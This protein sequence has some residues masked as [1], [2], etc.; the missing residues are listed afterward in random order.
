MRAT[1]LES[2]AA[3]DKITAASTTGG[4][5]GPTLSLK[6]EQPKAEGNP[7]GE[8]MYFVPLISPDLVEVNQNPG[9]LQRVRILSTTR[10]FKAGSFEV[11]GQFEIRGDG[12]QKNTF[13][14]T[15]S[16]R[17]EDKRL[18][19]G[20]VL[21]RQLDT[22][23]VSGACNGR[24]EVEGVISNQA[25]VVTMVRLRFNDGRQSPVSI[26]L[27]DISFADGAFH[28]DN[29]VVARVNALTFRRAPGRPKMEV[30]VGS[31]KDADAGNGF[32]QKFVGGMKGT[33]ANLL[34]KP[35]SVDRL[36]HATMLNFGLALANAEGQFTFPQA[37]NLKNPAR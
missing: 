15:N 30:T 17:R 31:V 11:V 32:W 27:H 37:K 18:K 5:V 4:A 21:K 3:A 9:N 16:I 36:G 28:Y 22:I 34:I 7:I 6:T 10:N 29:R 2:P 20:G 35:I 14:P 26:G 33:V 8:F 1:G 24:I 12:Y 13:D 19:E 25:P 23:T